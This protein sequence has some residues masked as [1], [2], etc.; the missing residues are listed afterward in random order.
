LDT[1]VMR[2]TCQ[3]FAEELT[4]YVFHPFRLQ[5]MSSVYGYELD[6]YIEYFM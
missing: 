4:A 5:T 1:I 2:K 6:E 3:S